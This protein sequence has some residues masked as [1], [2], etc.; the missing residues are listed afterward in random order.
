[1]RH[2][3]KALKRLIPLLLLLAG[4]LPLAAGTAARNAALCDRAARQAAQAA[5]VPLEI[6]RALTRTETG[7][8]REMAPWPW[9]VNLEGR[10]LWFDTAAE[11]QR[12]VFEAFQRGAR[13][14]DVG[15]FQ[16]NYRWHHEGFRSIEEMF[17]PVLNA[18]YAARFLRD[19]RRELGSWE[20]AVGAYHSRRHAHAVRYLERFAEVRAALPPEVPGRSLLASRGSLFGAGQA[21]GAAPLGALLPRGAGAARALL[22]AGGREP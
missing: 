5:D 9:T 13:S 21:L 19:L 1:M 14:F 7:R 4:A 12:H 3:R 17:D 15:C 8:G 20:R 10:G 18:R 6:L 16:I 2:L 11:A 22:P